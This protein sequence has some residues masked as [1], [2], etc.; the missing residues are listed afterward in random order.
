M[1]GSWAGEKGVS[2]VG[3]DGGKGSQ[4]PGR[5]RAKG[6]VA[7]CSCFALSFYMSLHACRYLFMVVRNVMVALAAQ[8]HHV[9][10]GSR[11]LHLR[12]V[13]FD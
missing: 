6:V 11:Q 2:E 12:Q 1:H 5:K 10:I 7:L 3:G 13:L 4:G 9:D 8:V